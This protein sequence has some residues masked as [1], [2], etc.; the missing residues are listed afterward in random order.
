MMVVFGGDVDNGLYHRLWWWRRPMYILMINS[1][2]FN[3]PVIHF[4]SRP[5]PS[6]KMNEWQEW[7]ERRGRKGT[8]EVALSIHRTSSLHQYVHSVLPRI[9]MIT[10]CFPCKPLH[11]PCDA[12]PRPLR[13]T[14]NPIDWPSIP[15]AQIRT[16]RRRFHTI[17]SPW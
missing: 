1:R 6:R 11:L 4:K 8:V 14:Q 2:R 13:W 15:R 7:D 5:K 16:L 3:V 10:N 12:Y 9:R 17:R